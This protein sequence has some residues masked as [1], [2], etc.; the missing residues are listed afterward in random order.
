MRLSSY[1][2]LVWPVM[3]WAWHGMHIDL[4]YRYFPEWGWG[5]PKLKTNSV[6][7]SLSWD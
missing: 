4:K 2:N 5:K 1:D 6:Q 3:V 7:Q